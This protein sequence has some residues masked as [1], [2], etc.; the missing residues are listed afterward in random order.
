MSLSKLY[1]DSVAKAAVDNSSLEIKDI[2]DA[3]GELFNRYIHGD[4]DIG[5]KYHDFESSLT[6]RGSYLQPCGSM[7]EKTA[8]WKS[9]RRHGRERKFLEFDFLTVLGNQDGVL[10]IRKEYCSGCRKI[11]REGTALDNG[12]LGF[13]HAFL[14]TLYCRINGWCNCHV[15]T[16]DTTKENDNFK[17]S[18]CDKCTVVKASGF[19]QIA[20]VPDFNYNNVKYTENCS[21]VLYWC[22]RNDSLL[23]P[24][25]ETLDLTERI[26]RLVIRVDILPAIEIPDEN[27]T[28]RSVLKRFVIQ[29]ECPNYWSHD[30]FMVSYCMFEWDAIRNAVSE[31]HKQCY[32]FMKFL[33]GQFIY[34]IESD[35]FLKSYH[36]KVA[37]LKHCQTCTDEEEDCTGCI[38]EILQSLLESYKTESLELPEFHKINK[39]KLRHLYSDIHIYGFKLCILSLLH[40][41]L[42]LKNH[43]GNT[44]YQSCH[45]ISLIKRTCRELLLGKLDIDETHGKLLL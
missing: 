33:Y 27:N 7:A 14:S 30:T 21:L 41:M 2:E 36:A 35:E 44:Q 1:S 43:P 38:M 31:K 3:V 19:L 8:L 10:D 25:I 5:Y 40:V 22:S 4:I 12:D 23:A 39:F 42:Q 15:E 9:V 29:K 13:G 24:N 17:I 32:T 37:F 20:K 34:W 26:N 18:H 16:D 45:L 28:D 6:F 11:L